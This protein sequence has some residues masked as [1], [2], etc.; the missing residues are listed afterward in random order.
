MQKTVG[1]MQS[2]RTGGRGCRWLREAG[3]ANINIDLMYG[4]PNQTT[5]D[6]RAQR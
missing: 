1:R 5:R 4:L 3:I 6:V 2:V